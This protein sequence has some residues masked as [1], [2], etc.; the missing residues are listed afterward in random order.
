MIQ[1]VAMRPPPN[2]IRAL[3]AA[4]LALWVAGCAASPERCGASAHATSSTP[5]AAAHCSFS[6]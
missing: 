4:I 6:F 2:L 5:G 1:S 3:G